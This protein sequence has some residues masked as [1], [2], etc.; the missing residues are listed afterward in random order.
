[1]LVSGT[2]LLCHVLPRGM[3]YASARATSI[4]LFVSEICAHSRFRS[5]VIAELSGPRLPAE[6]VIDLPSYRIASTLRRAAFVAIEM[7]KAAP[8][9]VL[10]QQHQPSAAAIAR[11][12]APPTILQKH[13]FIKEPRGGLIGRLSK[14]RHIREFNALAGLTLVSEAVLADFERHWPEVTIPRCVI[15]NGIETA[16]WRPAA[17][18]E[19]T[20]L[21]V[22]RAAPE[23][24]TLE[25]AQALAQALPRRDGWTATFIVS[26]PKRHSAY[27]EQV[28]AALAPLGPRAILRVGVPFA[29]VKA[30]SERAAIALI[31]SKWREPFGRTCLEAHAGGAAVISSGSGGLREISGDAALYLPQVDGAA[32]CS[33]LEALMDDDALR[34][35]LAQEGRARV[36]ARFDLAAV[37]ARLDDFCAER[38]EARRRALGAA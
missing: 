7:R 37:A 25:A 15:T 24:G 18:R 32:V 20:V 14:A 10:V 36:L 21:V 5:L 4:D 12:I 23:K 17:E 22:G 28:K 16:L 35:R 3:A 1:M 33:A 27:F 9:L 30:A 19:K 6:R 34:T 13:N 11:Q 31:P 2:A 29:E 26:E 38:I 8:G